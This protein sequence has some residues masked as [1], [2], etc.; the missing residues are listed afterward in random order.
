MTDPNNVVPF[1]EH[2]CVTACPC[3]SKV[4]VTKIQLVVRDAQALVKKTGDEWAGISYMW[5]EAERY[6]TTN[7][8]DRCA[9]IAKKLSDAGY[10]CMEGADIDEFIRF[11]AQ[12]VAGK[13]IE[14]E[15]RAGTKI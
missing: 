9:R 11:E 1:P 8:R 4:E 3:K 6:F 10:G 12:F 5:A 2:E 14:D 7:E 15:I 13:Q